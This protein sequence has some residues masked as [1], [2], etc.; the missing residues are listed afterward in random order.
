M[1][2]YKLLAHGRIPVPLQE[3]CCQLDLRDSRS[4]ELRRCASQ[5][6]QAGSACRLHG[7][8][9]SMLHKVSRLP[10]SVFSE[11]A[12]FLKGVG[13]AFPLDP[14]SNKACDKRSN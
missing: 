7:L 12:A 8:T 14:Q 9:V 2:G 4:R 1:C 6:R 10:V 13:L 5:K 11:R 3:A